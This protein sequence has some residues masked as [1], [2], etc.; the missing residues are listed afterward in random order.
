MFVSEK[1]IQRLLWIHI[2]NE[3]TFDSVSDS[4]GDS[5]SPKVRLKWKM[6][7]PGLIFARVTMIHFPHITLLEFISVRI[8]AT[9]C[10]QLKIPLYNLVIDI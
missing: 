4:V 6:L 8:A 2:R 9:P 5:L 7:F 10:G 1:I 3:H